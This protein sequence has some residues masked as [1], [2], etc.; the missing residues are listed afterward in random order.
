MCGIVNDKRIWDMNRRFWAYKKLPLNQEIIFASTGT[1]KP[2]DP[3]WK[4]VEAFA[5]SD[6]ETNPPATNDAVEASGRTI[7][8]QIDK[9]PPPEV[10]A[11][12]ER[13]VDMKHLEDTLMAEGVKKFAD[14]QKALLA[15]IAEK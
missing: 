3:P 10:V 1:K 5:G 6:I 4:Y 11:E 8:R 14:P 15:L 12:I 9:L 13:V 7:T 2:G